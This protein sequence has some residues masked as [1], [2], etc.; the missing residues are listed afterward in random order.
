M[1]CSSD[2]G[3]TVYTFGFIKAST[4]PAGITSWLTAAGGQILRPTYYPQSLS[5]LQAQ[6]VVGLMENILL[7]GVES[8]YTAWAT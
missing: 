8:F 5:F 3:D 7:S 1:V 2:S 6:S 4:Y